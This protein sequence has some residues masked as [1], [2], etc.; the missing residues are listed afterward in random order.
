MRRYIGLMSGTSMDGVDAAVVDMDTQRLIHG[1]TMPYSKAVKDALK[2]FFQHTQHSLQAISQL[3][4]LIG[5]DFAL[6]TQ[7]LLEASNLS[8]AD[9]LAIG[10]HGQTI[11]HDADAAIP[12]TVQLGCPHT[13]A[14]TSRIPV[15]ADFRTRDLIV[16]GQGAPLAPLY[17]QIL[18]AAL[19][20]PLAVVNVGGIANI[21]FLLGGGKALG[22][23]VG[24]GNCIMDAWVKKHMNVAYDHAGKWASKGKIILS[25][26]DCLMADL[27]VLKSPPKSIGKEYYSLNWLIPYLDESY[28][29]VDIQRTLLQFTALVIAQAIREANIPVQ[30]VLLCGG[31]VH[32]QLLMSEIRQQLQPI[33]VCSTDLFG[34]N[35]DFIEAQMMAWLADNMLKKTPLNLE[36]I[37]GSKQKT[38]LGVFYPPGIDK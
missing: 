27:F 34:V 35:P 23:D 1:L 24:P 13:I 21:T 31:G 6:A 19:K 37:T 38:I 28:T 15:V 14:Q 22:Y 18:F 10:S 30:Q 17:H 5:R 3:N 12:Y 2:E 7:Q 32:N 33:E 20:S 36:K 16:G 4:T 11:A 8:S 29:A 9:I 25:L 26:L